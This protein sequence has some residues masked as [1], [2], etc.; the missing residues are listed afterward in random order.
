MKTD[1]Q[2][3]NHKRFFPYVKLAVFTTLTGIKTDLWIEIHIFIGTE[4]VSGELILRR[5]NVWF[6][7]KIIL[8]V[9]VLFFFMCISYL[10]WYTCL[11]SLWNGQL[12]RQQY[13]L[14]LPITTFFSP[15]KHCLKTHHRKLYKPFLHGRDKKSWNK[16]KWLVPE[17]QFL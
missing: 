16:I 12:E 7:F 15:P 3:L 6:S 13:V 5:T 11:Y 14:C 10:A 1:I 8:N 17:I 4:Y 2:S 9:W